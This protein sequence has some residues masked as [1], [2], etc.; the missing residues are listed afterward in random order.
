MMSKARA[1][2]IVVLIVSSF[3]GA[4]TADVYYGCF[5]CRPVDLTST[6]SECSGVGDNGTGDGT[7]C[8]ESYTLPWPA[9]PTCSLSGNPCYNTVVTGGGGGSSGG[10]GGSTCA[11]DGNGYCA[12]WC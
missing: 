4:A 7:R 9:G 5:V 3:A 2:V 12:P 10:G 8:V 11:Y 1:M 6:A